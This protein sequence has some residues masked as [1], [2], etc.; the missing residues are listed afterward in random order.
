MLIVVTHFGVP[1]K[2]AKKITKKY[3]EESN[4]YILERL[5]IAKDWLWRIKISKFENLTAYFLL[6]KALLVRKI[7]FNDENPKLGV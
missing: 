3:V 4:I 1:H 6:I 2:H 5:G 7:Q